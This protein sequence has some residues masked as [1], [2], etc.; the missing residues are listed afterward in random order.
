[1]RFFIS[2]CSDEPAPERS[3]CLYSFYVSTIPLVTLPKIKKAPTKGGSHIIC[4][5]GEGML[6]QPIVEYLTFVKGIEPA[7]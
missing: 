5:G 4:C 7:S 6:L 2:V 1:V 3:T